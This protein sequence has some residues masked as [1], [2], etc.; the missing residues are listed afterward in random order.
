LQRAEEQ[1]SSFIYTSCSL[2]KKYGWF[3][4]KSISTCILLNSLQELSLRI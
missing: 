4:Y 1:Q 2:F 3:F